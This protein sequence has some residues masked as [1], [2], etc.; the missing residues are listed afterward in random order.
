MKKTRSGPL[1]VVVAVAA[2]V[3]GTYTL[4]S[5]PI[6]HVPQYTDVCRNHIDP[7]AEET[8]DIGGETCTID[9]NS[10]NDE[11]VGRNFTATYDVTYCIGDTTYCGVAYQCPIAGLQYA[12]YILSHEGDGW[13]EIDYP[14]FPYYCSGC[15]DLGYR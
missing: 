6:C 15:P 5:V 14:A 13:F 9:S 1:P 8:V 3:A 4:P 2:L 12:E 10:Y 11:L 7:A